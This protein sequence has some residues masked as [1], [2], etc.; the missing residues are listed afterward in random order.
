MAL[1]VP[2]SRRRRRLVVAATT[3]AVIGLV[4]GGAVWSSVIVEVEP[5]LE[6]S[7]AFVAGGVDAAVGQQVQLRVE[8][9]PVKLI[10]R[11]SL[12]AALTEDTQYRFGVLHFAYL[13]VH[14]DVI[15]AN[16]M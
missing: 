12:P 7:L 11:Q 5:G 4:A 8:Q 1:Y 2:Q 3:T 15:S 10:Q 14:S 6:G 16:F 9:L 13:S